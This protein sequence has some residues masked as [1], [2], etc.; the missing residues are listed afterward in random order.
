MNHFKSSDYLGKVDDKL[1]S[2]K[3]SIKRDSNWKRCPTCDKDVEIVFPANMCVS[4]KNFQKFIKVFVE[5]KAR[6]SLIKREYVKYPIT[7]VADEW[8][9]K[10]IDGMANYLDMDVCRSCLAKLGF[11]HHYDK[12]TQKARYVTNSV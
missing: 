6:W 11:R 4:D 2:N 8:D 7:Y 5:T 3:V 9:L 1:I 10:P 12:V